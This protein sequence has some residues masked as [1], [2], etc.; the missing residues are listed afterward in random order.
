MSQQIITFEAIGVIHSPHQEQ[1]GAPIQPYAARGISGTI[2]VFPEYREG[3]ADLRGFDR[4]W[5]LYWFH[6]TASCRLRVIPFRDVVERGLF[7]TRAP[8]RPNP[9]GLSAVGL[10]EVDE[11]G[12]LLKIEDV[13]MLDGTP[14]LD[15]KPYVPQFDAYPDAKAGWL[16]SS[17]K[18][19]DYADGR[20]EDRAE[21]GS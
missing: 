11:A 7:S 21:E 18:L 1:A 13:D 2:E 19:R 4:I 8:C 6:R 17:E 15:I 16:D 9:I 10:I 5:L 12:G 14:L 3:L 20:F